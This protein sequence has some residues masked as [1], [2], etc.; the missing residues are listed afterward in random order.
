MKFVWLQKINRMAGGRSIYH[1]TII[2]LPESENVIE[3]LKAI[4]QAINYHG[5]ASG[6][7]AHQPLVWRDN[8]AYDATDTKFSEAKYQIRI[9]TTPDDASL[10]LDSKYHGVAEI[11]EFEP[12]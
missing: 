6:D 2:M 10:Q 12:S 9:I 3:M 11:H 5:Y 1:D 7:W 8:A 4:A